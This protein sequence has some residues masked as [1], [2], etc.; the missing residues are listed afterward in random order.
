MEHLR[1]KGKD[2]IN[3]S[4]KKVMLRG[5]CIGGWMNMENFINGYPGTEGSLR[6]L[7]LEK[8]GED[9]GTFFFDEMIDNFLSEQDFK[10]IAE[11]GANCVRLAL[12]YRHFEDDENPFVY[13]EKGFKLLDKALDMCKKYNLYAILDMHAVQGWQNSHWHS[14]NIWGLSLLWRDKLYQERYYSLWQEIARRYADR[15]EVAGYDI[16]NEPS[17]NTS[18]GDF[19]YNCYENFKP[20]SE[21]FNKV[22]RTVVGKIREVDRR[23]IIFIE[24][25]YYGHIFREMEEP[26]DDNVVYSSHD[27]IVCG[28]GPGKYPGYFQQLRNDRIEESG[29]WNYDKQ[30]NHI[31]QTEAWQFAEKYKV[32][33]WVGEFGSQY[34]T[35]EEDVIYRLKSMDDQL[36]AF[37]ELGIHWTTWT[38]KDCGVMGWVTLSPDSEYIKI[39][40]PVQRMK[41]LLGAENFTGWRDITP[42]KRMVIQMAEYMENLFEKT[43]IEHNTNVRCLSNA[44][45]TGYAAQLLQVEYINLF[46]DYSKEDIKRILSSFNFKNCVVNTR[47]LEVLKRRLA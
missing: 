47:Y 16:M 9:I 35:G 32:P 46:K 8:L 44:V 38:Y 30:I 7:M 21:R 20:D 45:L 23:H 13:K 11:S 24:G 2:I 34:N 27:Y 33:L 26:F 14:D 12:N 28:F 1:V 4:N 31:L 15:N 22:V 19:P 42:G 29:E 10:F 5:T 3:E 41:M 39:I 6:A 37:N 17:S 18:I 36:K 43:K 40:E 25:D